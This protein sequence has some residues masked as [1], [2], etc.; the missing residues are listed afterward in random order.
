MAVVK[1]NAYGHDLSQY[2]MHIKESVD[3]FGVDSMAEARTLRRAGIKNPIL[4][5]GYTLPE[6]YGEAARLKVSLSFFN[7]EERALVAKHPTLKVHLKIDTGMHRQGIYVKDLPSFLKGI[8]AFQIEGVYTHFAGAKDKKFR[9]YTIAQI[10]NFKKA[11][12]LVCEKQ[13]NALCHASATSAVVN[14]PDSYFDMV[15]VGAGI[16][17]LGLS[18]NL[19]LKTEQV[20]SWTSVIGQVKEVE[21]GDYIG[22]DL[23]EKVSTKTKI[24]VV[25]IGYWH[26]FAR[27]LS[28]VGEVLVRGKRAKVL[29]IVSMDAFVIALPKNTSVRVG[30]KVTLIGKD[31]KECITVREMAKKLQTVDSEI[32]TKINPLVP[33]VFV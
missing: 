2:A 22:Y 14:Y 18:K 20:L 27:N 28:R 5:L 31:G 32:T 1:S 9:P 24:A 15:R 25:P 16:Y 7:A 29:G 17:G 12:A 33:R 13:P 30:D 21:K 19:P 6:L 26:G 11:T 23:T 8:S 10:E 3:W 4:V